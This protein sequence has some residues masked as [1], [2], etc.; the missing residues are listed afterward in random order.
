[1]IQDIAPHHLFNEFHPE[2]KCQPQDLVMVFKDKKLLVKDTDRIVFPKKSELQLKNDSIFLFSLDKTDFYLANE[3]VAAPAGYSYQTLRDLR[4]NFAEPQE[5]LYAAY[6][7]QHL[8]KWYRENKFCG[9]CGTETIHSSTER[10]KVCPTCGRIIY[11]RLNPAIIVAVTNGDKIILTRYANRP[12]AF[13]A[14]IAGFT[15]IGE[16]LEECVAREVKEEVGL[17]VKNMRYYKSQP[18]GTADD[19]LA[20]FFADVDGDD[21]IKVDH[22]ELK[23]AEWVAR[24]DII[25]QP[26]NLS[27]TNEMMMLFKAGNEPR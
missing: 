22:S 15:E 11:P 14:L 16:T 18:W 24:K 7:G 21:T 1:M 26:D 5:M 23:T 20:G 10:A 6:T 4:F 19:I 25:G 8:A 3:P 12:I 27:L 13:N 17:K 9:T 2:K